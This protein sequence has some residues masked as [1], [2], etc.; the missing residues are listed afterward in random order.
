MSVGAPWVAQRVWPMPAKPGMFL[1]SSVFSQS[2]A[3]LPLTFANAE[4]YDK[5][6]Q[7]HVLRLCDI[8]SGME[9]GEITVINETTGEEFKALCSFTQRQQ[10]ILMAGGLLNY[11]K[12]GGQ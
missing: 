4:D 2:L 3:I 9:H 7:S 12:E 6:E 5:L 1:P 11:T 8:R 10:A